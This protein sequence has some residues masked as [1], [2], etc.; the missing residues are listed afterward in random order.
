MKRIAFVVILLLIIIIGGYIYL[1]NG[2]KA[3]GAIVWVGEEHE[4]APFVDSFSLEYANKED[5]DC[6][7]LVDDENLMVAGIIEKGENGGSVLVIPFID[8]RLDDSLCEAPGEDSRID[9][10]VHYDSSKALKAYFYKIYEKKSGELYAKTLPDYSYL[11]VSDGVRTRIDFEERNRALGVIQY[12]FQSFEPIEWATVKSFN[13]QDQVIDV[14]GMS[15]DCDGIIYIPKNTAYT[16]CEFQRGNDIERKLFEES[17]LTY[18]ALNKKLHIGV[19][20][21]IKLIKGED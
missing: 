16:I 21:E 15:A 13:S 18:I 5:G 17:E 10:T 2:D 6:E 19:K 8:K 7:I 4:E 14:V 3:I 1:E 12:T 20:S 11:Y 9:I